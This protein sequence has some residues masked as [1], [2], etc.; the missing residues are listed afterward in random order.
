[1]ERKTWLVGRSFVRS[2]QY[3]PRVCSP[4]TNCAGNTSFFPTYWLNPNSKSTAGILIS[5]KGF[6]L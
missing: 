3:A 1:M 6:W 4:H 2:V 5:W